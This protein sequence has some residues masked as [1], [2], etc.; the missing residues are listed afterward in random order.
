MLE[1][2]EIAA[3]PPGMVATLAF[4]TGTDHSVLDSDP[5]D[6]SD[7]VIEDANEVANADSSDTYV[8]VTPPVVDPDE[9]AEDA[10]PGAYALS[11]NFPNPFNP[12]T[13]IQYAIPANGAGHVELV[14]YNIN[15]Q[16][17]R[18]LVNETAD[19]GFYS[20]VWDGRNDVGEA[21]SSGIYLYRIV[22][23]SF[24]KIEKMTF[25]K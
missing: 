12:T 19:A 6:P 25:M 20:V 3:I 8:D 4:I 24:V 18:T 1:V 15:A 13:T 22:S 21:V 7:G 2:Q 17:V 10:L 9:V 16:K 5:S 11:K 14:I 23:G